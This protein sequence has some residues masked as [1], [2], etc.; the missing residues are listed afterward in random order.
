MKRKKHARDILHQPITI[1][2]TVV[3]NPAN[4][5]GIRIGEVTEVRR[6]GCTIKYQDKYDVE[7]EERRSA[8]CVI[9]IDEQFDIAKENNPEFYI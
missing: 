8:S 3:Y 7:R 5:K 4:C 6:K 9:C 1:G 2:C